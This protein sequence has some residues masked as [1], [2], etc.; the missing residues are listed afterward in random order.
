MKRRIFLTYVLLLALLAP[1]IGQQPA[2]SNPRQT[3][4]KNPPGGDE[5]V[6]ITTNLVQVD[7][8]VTDKKGQIVTDL[9]PE[10]FDILEDGRPQTI[11]NFSFVS[12]V[13]NA[14]GPTPNATASNNK[15]SPPVPPVRLRPEQVCRTI[16]LVVDDLCMAFE[17]TDRVREALRKFVE[18]QM[19]P[20]DLVSIFRARGGNGALQQFTS[21]KNQLQRAIRQIRWYPP[22]PGDSCGTAFDDAH[23]DYTVKVPRSQG[24]A[25]ARTF[26]NAETKA[27]R[28]HGEDFRR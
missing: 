12:L 1:V 19:L 18:E 6:R 23:S 15:N 13:P 4:Q 28:E 27:A 16:A 9:K 11:T 5:V 8:V 20:G 7:A 14:D 22:R 26:E 24:P 3:Q 21:D 25:G 17:S 10:E 2:T